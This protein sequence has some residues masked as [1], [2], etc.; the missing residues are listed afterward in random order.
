MHT[1]DTGIEPGSK[2]LAAGMNS[3]LEIFESLDH[4]NKTMSENNSQFIAGDHVS[5][6]DFLIFG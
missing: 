3:M 6:F 2:S 4:L 1:H 5:V